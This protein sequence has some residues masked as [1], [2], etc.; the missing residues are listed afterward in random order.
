M[1]VRLVV[2]FFPP[3]RAHDTNP[4]PL[5]L[6]RGKPANV[7]DLVLRCEAKLHP[8]LTHE[9]GRGK[10]LVGHE[11]DP[12]IQS[13]DHNAPTAVEWLGTAKSG[14]FSQFLAQHSSSFFSASPA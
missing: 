1:R 12:P 3:S 10:I 11:N 7:D 9:K 14:P 2:L 4:K 13:F 6:A 8:E 5:V